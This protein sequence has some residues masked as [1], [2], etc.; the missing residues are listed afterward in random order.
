MVLGGSIP[1]PFNI[2]ASPLIFV[3]GGSPYNITTGYDQNQDSLYNDRPAFLPGASSANCH[4]LSSFSNPPVGTAY[5]PIP[6]NYCTGPATATVNLR[7][8]E[9]FG[10]GPKDRVRQPWP[11][12]APG[13]GSRRPRGR[14]FI[15][16]R[17]WWCTR[18]GS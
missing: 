8:T 6:V 1:L 11:L 16:R 3:N 5:T 15:R 4:D 7:L 12:S 13:R 2:T 14:S 18:R 17:A 9:T 10:I